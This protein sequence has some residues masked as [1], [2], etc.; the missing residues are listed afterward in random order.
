M[1]WRLVGGVLFPV[2]ADPVAERRLADSQLPC[3][4]CDSTGSFHDHPG[5]LLPEFRRVLLVFLVTSFPSFPVKILKD[6]QSGK[7]GAPYSEEVVA[8]GGG[9]SDDFGII[10]WPVYGLGGSRGGP[11]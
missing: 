10:G 6:P 4:V 1:Q 3:H 5:C 9:G 8:R 11:R 7:L 2:C